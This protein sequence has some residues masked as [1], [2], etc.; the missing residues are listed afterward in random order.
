MCVLKK[1]TQDKSRGKKKPKDS[2]PHNQPICL[3]EGLIKYMHYQKAQKPM[4]GY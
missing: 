1:V 4:D 3:L 2:S